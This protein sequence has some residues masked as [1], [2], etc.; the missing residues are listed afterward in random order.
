M[1]QVYGIPNCDT[2]KKAISWLKQNNIAFEFH[3]FKKE[4]IT[5]LKLKEWLKTASVDKV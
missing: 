2:V 4:G 1:V 3:D 5:V